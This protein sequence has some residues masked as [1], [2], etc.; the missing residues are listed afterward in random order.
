MSEIHFNVQRFWE[1][2]DISQ[3]PM[4]TAVEQLCEN[5][6]SRMHWRNEEGHYGLYL[7]MKEKPLDS[8]G[9]SFARSLSVLY[10]VERQLA[11]N[12]NSA[13]NCEEFFDETE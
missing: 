7:P 8:I 3:Q 5:Y 6:F 4:L 1:L 2:E 10:S 13:K 9:K 11:H 12:S